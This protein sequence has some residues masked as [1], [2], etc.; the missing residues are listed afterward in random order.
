[1]Y[2]GRFTESQFAKVRAAVCGKKVVDFGAGSLAYAN[3][4][5]QKGGAANIVAIDDIFPHDVTVNDGAIRVIARSFED[6]DPASLIPYDVAF[7]SKPVNRR[8]MPEFVRLVAMAP[9][10][11][12]AGSNTDVS[13]SG[14]WDLF[15]QFLYR[16]LIAYEYARDNALIVM[17]PIG[18][19]V[20]QPTGEE[21]AGLMNWSGGGVLR[22]L[23]AEEAAKTANPYELLRKVRQY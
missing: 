5:L 1:M 15:R 12:Y 4:L 19:A 17:G 20:R 6:I 16:E 13:A 10:V 18:G 14:S 21:F 11:V 22:D 23:E 8:K 3:I 9:V 7:L 2:I